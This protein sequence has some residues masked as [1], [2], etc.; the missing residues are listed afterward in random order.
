MKWK[1]PKQNLI[2]DDLDLGSSDDESDNETDN[3]TDIGSDS[4]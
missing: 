1:K 4:K 2:N 3:E